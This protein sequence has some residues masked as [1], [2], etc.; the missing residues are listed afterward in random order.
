MM[1]VEVAR[2]DKCEMCDDVDY[3]VDDDDEGLN[4]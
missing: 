3:K 2:E 4:K 1:L